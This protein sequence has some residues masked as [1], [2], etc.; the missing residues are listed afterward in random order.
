MSRPPAD[1]QVSAAV[2]QMVISTMTC[3]PRLQGVRV[4]GKQYIPLEGGLILAGNHQTNFDPFLSALGTRRF[5]H[6][7]TKKELFD[8]P[9]FSRVMTAGG[10]FAVD[11]S[12]NDIGAIR[13]ALEILKGDGVL[14]IFPQG[15]RGGQ[16]PLDGVAY[17]ALK[18]KSPIIPMSIL[19]HKGRWEIRYGVPIP[20]EGKIKEL[21]EKV[22]TSIADLNRITLEQ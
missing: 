15:T 2:Y 12:K 5:I 17:L 7:M 22:M 10:S 11:R 18:S 19:R 14:G 20:P 8:N 13:K 1:V 6:Y 21:T 3:I 16:E 4:F 9:F